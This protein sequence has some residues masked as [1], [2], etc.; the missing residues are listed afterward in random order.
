MRVSTRCYAVTGLGYSTPW[1]VN[2]GFIAGDEITLIVDAGANTLSAQTIHGYA[3]AVRPGNQLAVINTEKHFD[4]IGGNGYFR[5]LDIDVWGHP[6]ITRTADEFAAEMEEFNCAIGNAQRRQA[7]EAAVFYH[8]TRLAN[9]NCRVESGMQFD[10]GGCAVEILATPGHTPT[11]V[12]IWVP[13]DRV[14]YTGD[15]LINL[16]LP[17]LDAGNAADWRTW[18]DSLERLESLQP[19]A[20]V[21]GHG[22]VARGEEVPAVMEA[23]RRIL[24]ESIARGHSPTTVSS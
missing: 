23:V 19:A 4:H 21:M 2:A 6:A 5:S 9:P 10:L 14:L 18:L 7:G 22:P 12:S 3:S 20:I 16:Y 13:E 17:N 1:C 11:N 8:D 15:C 24:R